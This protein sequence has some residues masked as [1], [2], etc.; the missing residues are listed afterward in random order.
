MNVGENRQSNKLK[1]PWEKKK[2]P[3]KALVWRSVY[4]LQEL[5]V[6]VFLKGTA[7]FCLGGGVGGGG[8]EGWLTMWFY[9]KKK[10]FKLQGIFC[11]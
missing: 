3:R 10:V 6:L 8:G 4:N 7:S 5:R 9:E 11:V 1:L 2:T